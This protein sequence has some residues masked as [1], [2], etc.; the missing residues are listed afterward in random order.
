[1]S[2]VFDLILF[3]GCIHSGMWPSIFFTILWTY[4]SGSQGIHTKNIMLFSSMCRATMLWWKGTSSHTPVAW[5]AA[6]NHSAVDHN[7]GYCGLINV[8]RTSCQSIRHLSFLLP[9]SFISN[10]MA[11]RRRQVSTSTIDNLIGA[12]M[13]F[14]EY[15]EASLQEGGFWIESSNL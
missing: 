6:H 11:N 15:N 10:I 9:P 1:M 14:K 13:R 2:V 12:L 7:T 8:S 5:A 4:F 3:C